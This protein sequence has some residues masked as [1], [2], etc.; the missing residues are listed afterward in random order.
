MIFLQ[1][2]VLVEDNSWSER[3]RQRLPRLTQRVRPT[4]VVPFRTAPRR[5]LNIWSGAHQGPANQTT[6]SACSAR[7]VAQLLLLLGSN[8]DSSDP[9]CGS[10]RTARIRAWHSHREKGLD[11]IKRSESSID[12][13][14]LI[15]APPNPGEVR[16]PTVQSECARARSICG[17]SS[18]TC[19]MA[20]P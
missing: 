20:H 11:R 14:T 9:V 3:S 7:T 6:A 12:V 5:T 18:G 19:H 8:Q 17:N 2:G 15:V 13:V 10:T 4:P 16:E 1:G